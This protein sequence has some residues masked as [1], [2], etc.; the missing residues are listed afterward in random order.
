MSTLLLGYNQFLCAEALL[1][2]SHFSLSLFEELNRL[3]ESVVLYDRVM[4]LGDYATDRLT[5]YSILEEA[6]AISQLTDES[7]KTTL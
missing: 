1:R 5:S 4:L 2:G 6:G 3:I 7:L